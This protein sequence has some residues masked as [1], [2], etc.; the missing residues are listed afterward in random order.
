MDNRALHTR[1]QAEPL[2]RLLSER[3]L[4]PVHVPLICRQATQAPPPTGA[5]GVV[6]LTSPAA[7]SLAVGLGAAAAAATVVAVGPATAAAARACG[8]TDIVVAG[9][10]GAAAVERASELAAGQSIWHVRGA[11]TSRS[12][13][14]ALQRAGLCPV[15]WV[16]YETS[17]APGAA[18][19]LARMVPPAVVC[20]ASGS[21]AR[22]YVAAGG[23]RSVRV[24]VIGRDTEAETR[25]AG[26]AV[27]AVAATPDLVG[28]ADAARAALS[29]PSS[30]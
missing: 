24:A 27:H 23:S 14:A 15:S 10:G 7:A 11:R 9:G 8:Q 6:L 5:P 20:F 22:A 12:V 16:V 29:G 25:S 19:T 26:L 3:G 4:V 28:L 30:A 1:E 18:G 13:A 17:F 21:A 2:R